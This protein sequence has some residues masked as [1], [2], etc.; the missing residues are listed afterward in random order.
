MN[1][2]KLIFA[3]G[4]VA[5]LLLNVATFIENNFWLF[6]AVYAFAFAFGH[7]ITYMT[8]IHHSWLFFP[9]QGGLTSGIIL[10]GYGFGALVFDNVSTALVN[11]GGK[12]KKDENG[13]YPV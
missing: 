3:G 6:C 9:K 4:F 1:P 12:Y 2:K 8:A 5:F 7:A 11:P 10:G 13:W